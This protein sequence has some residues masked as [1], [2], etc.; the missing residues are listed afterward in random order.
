MFETPFT[1]VGTIV[2]DPVRRRVGDQEVIKFRL[3]SN[4][5]RRSAE[6][7]WEPGQSL[8]VTVSCWGRLVTGVGAS[9]GKGH[10]VIVVGQ[11]HT[12]EYEDRDGNR[13]SSVEVRATAVGPD[14]S[15]CIARVSNVRHSGADGQAE[16][17]PA[18]GE[19]ATTGEPGAGV[20]P[21]QSAE[22]EEAQAADPLP[23]SA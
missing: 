7:T 18:D 23:L 19:V 13:R 3:A 22:T 12:N 15:R 20:E 6:G 17:A 11:I 9:L 14:L 1:V 4:S 5:R 2:N 21:G 10:A 16:P 8:F